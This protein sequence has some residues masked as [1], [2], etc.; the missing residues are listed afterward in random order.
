MSIWARF[1]LGVV[2]AVSSFILAIPGSAGASQLLE[3][4]ERELRMQLETM[5]HSLVTIVSVTRTRAET[6]AGEGEKSSPARVLVRRALGC[7]VVLDSLGT[8]LTTCSV[9]EGADYVQV[10][11][12]DG[13]RVS[14]DILGTDPWT[15]LALLQAKGS[16]WIGA[17]IGNSDLLRAGSWVTVMGNPMG[18]GPSVT[19]GVVRH[20]SLFPNQAGE[21]LIQMN[22]RVRP[23]DTGGVV[24]NTRGEA[25]GIVCGALA[26]PEGGSRNADNADG[27]GMQVP[28]LP[29][30]HEEGVSFAVPLATALRVAE[31]LRE[32]GEMARG[33]LGVEI[34]DE[35]K[36]GARAGEESDWESPSRVQVVHVYAGS[37]AEKAGLRRGDTVLEANGEAVTSALALR[38]LVMESLPGRVIALLVERG[39]ETVALQVEVGRR[40]VPGEAHRASGPARTAVDPPPTQARRAR[41]ERMRELEEEL[42]T[43]RRQAEGD[44]S[45]MVSV[46][47]APEKP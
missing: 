36:R 3:E 1:L 46:D 44:P 21:R 26:D 2:L 32:H 19:T 24:M 6:T 23:G 35:P 43:L 22:L 30:G 39:N 29:F 13:T 18:S 12:R 4:L 11:A 42:A 37:P 10:L 20:R 5:E 27:A 31:R 15:E 34:S 9:V 16:G 38:A 33:Y 40:E 7:G 8:I 25:V 47:E 41:Q 45:G 17:P 14:A 28:G